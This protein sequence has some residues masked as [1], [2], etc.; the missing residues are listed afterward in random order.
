[1]LSMTKAKGDSYEKWEFKREGGTVL[2]NS[3][4]N[5]IWMVRRMVLLQLEWKKAKSK[6]LD[7]EVIIIQPLSVQI[8]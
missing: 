7:L 1:M 2:I 8:K 3:Q 4:E 5:L 6:T